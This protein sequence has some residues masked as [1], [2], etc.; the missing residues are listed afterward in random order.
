MSSYLTGMN[1]LV[2]GA[3]DGIGA[4]IAQE[5]A[6]S[7]V[8]S[9]ILVGRDKD[10]LELVS[11]KCGVPTRSIAAD[12]SSQE[13]L[14]HLIEKLRGES[15]DGLVNNAGVGLG[16][17]F[18]ELS[19]SEQDRMIFLN[20][21]ALTQLSHALLPEM[22]RRERGF[23]LFVGSMIGFV[24]GP[25]MSVYSGTKG[26]VNR[27]AESLRWEL[28]ESSVR[29]VLLTPGVTR[30][31]FFRSAG[32]AEENIRSGQ[33]TAESVAR[34]AMNGLVRNRATVVPGIRNR[35]LLLGMKLSPRWLVGWVS[36]TIFAGI[37]QT[38]QR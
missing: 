32:I 18:E 16:G 14:D 33:M 10:R 4:A 37:T 17:K 20:T 24:G 29:V 8:E 7:G 25:G 15:V 26:Y 2:T 3:S 38:S 23:I 6:R 13:G 27:F 19:I 22:L 9:L 31:S 5:L 28:S 11:G 34:A 35:L 1:V 36:R 12:L 30:T 21:Q